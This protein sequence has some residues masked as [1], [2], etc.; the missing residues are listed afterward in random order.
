MMYEALHLF[1]DDTAIAA[2]AGKDEEQGPILNKSHDAAIVGAEGGCTLFF[3]RRFLNHLNAQ[4]SDWATGKLG[5][6]DA[7][8]NV[9]EAQTAPICN[10]VRADAEFC[11]FGEVVA[12][13]LPGSVPFGKAF[14][15]QLYVC[16]KDFVEHTSCPL[17]AWS[18]V[19]MCLPANCSFTAEQVEWRFRL[20]TAFSSTVKGDDT[21][22]LDKADVK[23]VP[24]TNNEGT[25][26]GFACEWVF[27]VWV[28]R[29]T[30]SSVGKDSVAVTRAPIEGEIPLTQKKSAAAPATKAAAA[31]WSSVGVPGARRKSA[32]D[33]KDE[34]TEP[35]LAGPSDKDNDKANA[36]KALWRRCKHL[37]K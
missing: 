34:K 4:F 15:V 19:T 25:I 36:L 27:N 24:A 20:P 29:P 11:F 13:A 8:L 7:A 3:F 31:L 37:L 30:A 14:G 22:L 9:T 28:L 10:F 23:L 12:E 1:H 2:D 33:A 16:G 32:R 35:G 18:A 5:L 21:A 6:Q 17:P 26:V